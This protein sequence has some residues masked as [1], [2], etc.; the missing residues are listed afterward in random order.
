MLGLAGMTF[1]KQLHSP[2]ACIRLWTGVENDEVPVV[3]TLFA[4]E[5][6]LHLNDFCKKWKKVRYKAK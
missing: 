2:H 3:L 6:C 5:H 4:P 1:Q